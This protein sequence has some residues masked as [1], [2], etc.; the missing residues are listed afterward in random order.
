MFYTVEVTEQE[1]ERL[2]IEKLPVTT[3]DL[4]YKALDKDP[5]R[6]FQEQLYYAFKHLFTKDQKGNPC[7]GTVYRFEVESRD[8]GNPKNF[9]IAV[10]NMHDQRFVRKLQ[11]YKAGLDI[12]AGA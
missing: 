6:H 11:L 4:I 3:A 9:N 7:A 5:E 1:I 12:L 2:R 8:Q 10:Y